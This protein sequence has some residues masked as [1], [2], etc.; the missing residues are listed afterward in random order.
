MYIA[1]LVNCLTVS[2]K[3]SHVHILQFRSSIPMYIPQQ[4]FSYV[5]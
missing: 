1:I 5:H 2:T 3:D 4:K